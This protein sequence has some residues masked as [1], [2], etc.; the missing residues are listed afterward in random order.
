MPAAERPNVV[1]ILADDLG[2]ADLAVT[3]SHFYETPNLDRLAAAGMRFTASYAA[4]PVC[5]PTRAAL[6][7]GRYPARLGLTNFI[8]G[9]RR[10]KL[11]PASYLHHLPLEQVTLAECFR[12]AGYATFAI[13]KWHLGDEGFGP[14]EQ[15]F[16]VNIG[17]S[18]KGATSFFP[19][20]RLANLSDKPGCYLTDRLTEEAISWIER[21]GNKP[22]FLWLAHYDVHIPLQARAD[23]IRR[24]E[25]KAAT[26][27][28]D[29]RFRAE[30]SVRDRR[31][32]DHAVYAAKVAS[33]D[34]SVGRVLATLDRL[35]LS[36]RTI[37]VFTSDNGGLSTAEGS[38]TSNAPLRAG[39]G[40]LYE[41][42]IRVPLLLRG[43]SVPPGQLCDVPVTSTDLFPT[44]LELAGL[45]ARPELALDGTSL[46]SLWA[47]KSKWAR[48]EL[49]WHYPHYSNQGGGPA[50][51]IRSGDWKLIEF[52]ETNR[53][54]LY[55]L[56]S[57]AG[58]QTD[59]AARHP[60]RARELAA[61]LGQWRAS[62]GA[63]MPRAE[64]APA[65]AAP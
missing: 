37:V 65:A 7:T 33:L 25:E 20:Y 8:P 17:G 1:F 43:P 56:R 5:S 36:R 42:G 55:D 44:L 12:Q 34:E 64:S 32:Q 24:F 9:A 21:A 10:G 31:I 50:S 18:A 28:A 59:L 62:V 39:K 52:F 13:G 47:S 16:D 54:E 40:W 29:E 15:G 57:D 11:L 63:R 38:P 61:R 35:E 48:T 14:L 22:F 19:P 45:P 23:L 4:A 51:A 46:V 6:L 30:G 2:W 41:G 3:G 27:P 49:F 58:E 60:E 53:H 26:L